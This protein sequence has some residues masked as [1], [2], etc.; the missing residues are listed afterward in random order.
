MAETSMYKMGGMVS[1]P[2][3]ADILWLNRLQILVGTDSA[4]EPREREARATVPAAR[5]R[6]LSVRIISAR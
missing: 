2:G 3:V 4:A 1:P 5:C 6:C